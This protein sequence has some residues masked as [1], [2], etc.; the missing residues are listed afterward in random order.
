MTPRNIGPFDV[1]ALGIGWMNLSHAYGVAPAPDAERL[2][3]T[4]L[5]AGVLAEIDTERCGAAG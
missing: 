5:E 4:A 1:P 2:L 3:R